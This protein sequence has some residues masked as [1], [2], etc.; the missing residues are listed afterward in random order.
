MAAGYAYSHPDAVDGLVFWGAYPAS[1]NSL[2][3]SKLKV[4]SI[5]G[6]R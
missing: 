2:V 1:N 4:T 5:S 6:T 3:G